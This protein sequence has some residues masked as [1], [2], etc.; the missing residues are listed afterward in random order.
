MELL[1]CPHAA[2]CGAVLE[3]PMQSCSGLSS[4][5][6]KWMNFEENMEVILLLHHR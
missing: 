5:T 2:D 4:I 1:W 6:S 3:L